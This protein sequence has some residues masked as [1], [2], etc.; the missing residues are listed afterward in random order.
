MLDGTIHNDDFQRNTASLQCLNK[1]VTIRNNVATMLQ[2]GKN[3]RFESSR[4]TSPSVA[5]A[6]YQMLEVLAFAIGR[7]LNLLQ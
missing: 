2:R 5:G 4:V 3:C 1:I 6:S 7:G